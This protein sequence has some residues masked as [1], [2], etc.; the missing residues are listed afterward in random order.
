MAQS[1]FT[2]IVLYHSG[3][4]GNTPTTITTGELA[5]NITDGKLFLGTGTN[6]YNTL[7]N[8]GSNTITIGG[9]VTFSGAYTTTMTVTGATS[10]TLPTSGTV[11]SS[12]TALPGAV[13]GTPSSTTYLRGDGTWATVSGGATKSQAIAYAIVFGL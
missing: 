3:T 13:T 9:N 2:P 8:V 11:I 7:L 1:G 12:V 5:V 6:T 10:V 4:T